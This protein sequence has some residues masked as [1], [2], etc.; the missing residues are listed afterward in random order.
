MCVFTFASSLCC[1]D[2]SV[3]ALTL[4]C[5]SDSLNFTCGEVG[6]WG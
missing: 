6:R 2:S 5:S 1:R 4:A 3:A